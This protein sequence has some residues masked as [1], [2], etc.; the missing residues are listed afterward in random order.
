MSKTT[1]NKPSANALLKKREELAA[2]GI[3]LREF[4]EAKE[5]SYQAAR[6]ILCGKA[7][8]RRGNT[9]RAAVALGLKP[10]PEKL[11]A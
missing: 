5:I 6:E 4:C 3:N 8:G 10:N 9:H 2:H 11:A 1:I 7:S